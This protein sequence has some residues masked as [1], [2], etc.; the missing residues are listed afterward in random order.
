MEA[1][2]RRFRKQARL[3][4]RGRSGT[5]RRYSGGLRS[6]GVDYLRHQARLG[7]SVEIVASELGV[8]GW[9]LIRWS[10]GAQEDAR[11]ALR[12]V[13][14]VDG[15]SEASSSAVVTLVTPD[16]YRVEGLKGREIRS[17]MEALR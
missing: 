7:A 17:L 15:K 14:V 10:R 4:N 1:R 8:S 2:V 13:E 5:S 6:L 11:P 9:S 16:G 12:E 3:E